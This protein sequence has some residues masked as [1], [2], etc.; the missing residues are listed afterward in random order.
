MLEHRLDARVL[1]AEGNPV[2][3]AP[4][5]LR[6]LQTSPAARQRI[7]VEPNKPYMVGVYAPVY[8]IPLLGN[9]GVDAPELQ[10]GRDGMHPVFNEA[11]AA[12][13]G[14]LDGARQYLLQHGVTTL[15]GT[16][17]FA[18]AFAKWPDR[19]ATHFSTVFRS[20]DGANVILR[21]Q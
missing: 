13:S 14:S 17:R 9:V 4:D 11:I 20:A 16:G 19:D 18:Q 7:Q 12:G 6:Y 3:L 2:E 1:Y 8:V 5:T 21:V 15:L 10:A